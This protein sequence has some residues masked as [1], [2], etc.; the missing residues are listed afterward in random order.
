ML[1]DSKA[2]VFFHCPKGE[3]GSRGLRCAWKHMEVFR[4][5]FTACVS[6]NGTEQ[7][8]FDS[9]TDEEETFPNY[10]DLTAR[11][12]CVAYNFCPIQSSDNPPPH[13]LITSSNNFCFQCHF[14]LAAHIF[15]LMLNYVF[16]GCQGRWMALLL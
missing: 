4:G 1:L 8:A 3:M 10:L 2:C 11:I 9:R 14:C 13:P 5:D 12:F 15:I 6:P 16:S 7:N